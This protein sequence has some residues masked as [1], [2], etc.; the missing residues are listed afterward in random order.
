MNR[1][2]KLVLYVVCIIAVIVLGSIT[3]RK[4]REAGKTSERRTER[5]THAASVEPTNS[6]EITNLVAEATNLVAPA[7]LTNAAATN[8]IEPRR[9][10]DAL[11]LSRLRQLGLVL[12]SGCHFP[13]YGLGRTAAG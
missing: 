9:A 8:E 2:V 13:A 12:D 11:H 7:T 1:I 10:L 3:V 5:I 6:A 4:Y